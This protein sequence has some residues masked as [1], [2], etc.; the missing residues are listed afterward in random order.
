MSRSTTQRALT[1]LFG[2][3]VVALV[4][5]ASERVQIRSEG[6]LVDESEDGNEDRPWESKRH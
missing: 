2:S 4:D 3:Q 6:A 1:I 5:S